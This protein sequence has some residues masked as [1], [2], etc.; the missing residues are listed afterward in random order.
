[1]Q[2]QAKTE[3]ATIIIIIIIIALLK[4]EKEHNEIECETNALSFS[5]CSTPC[6]QGD[7]QRKSDVHLYAAQEIRSF[8]Q[9]SPVT[10]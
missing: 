6:V 4:R 9:V 8:V 3:Q 5:F 1:M 7:P 10:D 2:E